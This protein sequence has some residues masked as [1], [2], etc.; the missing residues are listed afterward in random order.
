MNELVNEVL[1]LAEGNA[2]WLDHA[3]RHFERFAAQLHEVEKAQWHLL[4][5][6]YRER[7]QAIQSKA[8]KVRQSLVADACSELRFEDTNDLARGI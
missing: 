2:D 5:A 8:E 1:S 3:A 4:A 7:A 6:V